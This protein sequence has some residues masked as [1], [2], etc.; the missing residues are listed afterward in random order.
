MANIDLS[1]LKF[2]GLSDTYVIPKGSA[3][4]LYNMATSAD[5]ETARNNGATP[6]FCVVPQGLG[7]PGILCLLAERDSAT[8][9][10]FLGIDKSGNIHKASCNNGTWGSTTISLAQPSDTPP[11]GLGVA[12]AGSSA[13]YSRSDHVHAM[14]SASDVGA[15]AA[16]SSP[17]VGDFLMYTSNGWAAQSLS[18]WQGGNY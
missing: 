15:I 11:V 1:S 9:H 16:P 7:E 17:T 18:A 8:L 14:P 12:A 2:P 10:F 5:I 13:Y 6:V 3:F 4:V